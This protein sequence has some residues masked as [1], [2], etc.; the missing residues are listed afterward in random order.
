[1]LVN[2]KL[3][4]AE[5]PFKWR[6]A[7]EKGG[8]FFSSSALT[9]SN[10]GYEKICTQFNI[11]VLM[12]NLGAYNV[13]E[14]SFN[15]NS[16]KLAIKHFQMAASIF[17]SL[18]HTTASS[19]HTSELSFDL[20]SDVLNL[21]QHIMLA[22][23][24]ETF[25]FKASNDQMKVNSIA[26]IVAQCEDFYSEVNKLMQNI[27]YQSKLAIPDWVEV[28]QMKQIAYKGIAEY[29]QALVAQQSKDF[30]E[31]I[32]RLTKA[33][34]LLNSIESK[35]SIPLADKFKEI[36]NKAN[37]SL[38]E[39]KRDNDFIY[40][41][42][43]P[44]YKSLP[45]VSKA[46]L[47][48]CI[49]VAEIFYPGETDLLENL[50]PFGVHKSIQSLDQQ[51][52][53]IVN[54]EISKLREATQT[55]NAILASLNLP[56]AIEDVEGVKVPQSM[57]SKADTIKEKGGI[58]ELEKL[59]NELPDLLK[60]N[61]EIID[62]ME[63]S[64]NGEEESDNKLREQFGAKWTRAASNK[65]NKTWREH[66]VKYRS[67]LQ[68]ATD[69]DQ[70]VN[71]K[72]NANREKMRLLS[73]ATEVSLAQAIPSNKVDT[74][75]MD[76]SAVNKL[77]ELLGHVETLKREREELENQIKN[78]EFD[79]MKSKFIN[80][81]NLHQDVNESSLQSETLAEFYGDLQ[82]KVRQSLEKQETLIGHI[83]RANDAFVSQKGGSGND[84]DQF[85]KEL[86]TAHDAFVELFANL[87]E[88]TTFYNNLT[89]LLVNLQVKVND[90][91]FARKAERE[92]L[93]K[94][95]Q[96]EVVSRPNDPV[97]P[98]PA[99]QT[100]AAPPAANPSKPERPLP[101]SIQSTNPFSVPPPPQSH[102]PTY[103][104][105]QPQTIHYPH[106]QTG[107]QYNYYPPP[108]LP[109]GYNPYMVAPQP[110]K[111]WIILLYFL[112]LFFVS[113][114]SILSSTGLPL[115]RLS[116]IP[117]ASTSIGLCEKSEY[118]WFPLLECISLLL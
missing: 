14:S 62:D 59:I 25:Y 75:D 58:D 37:Q 60:R 6:D 39:V 61:K 47:A 84:R 5:I 95:L 34:E 108:P 66:I 81:F 17:Q 114:K 79:Q 83:R 18:K 50:L 57:L 22:Q 89:Q 104:F 43:I 8:Y 91:C 106:P 42:K 73:N 49:D 99:Y 64:L 105:Y 87:K 97:P 102:P 67:I 72:F 92:E 77:R 101:P 3:P 82:R 56:A 28:F 38:E 12:S 40:H 30:G 21:L 1:M 9:V 86:A 100:P 24:Q 48:K 68:N 44:D 4:H 7:F 13:K 93:C 74:S 69:A 65:L 31:Q 71:A 35:V 110:G 113:R 52:Q 94:D 117:T 19:A 36:V 45:Q 26:R 41:A 15:D 46:L 112:T 27:P 16:L 33:L 90:F 96:N 98:A 10:I 53:S 55:I 23:A 107:P 51:K 111:I 118:F 63:R 103:P 54:T 11:A 80:A 2:N 85:L 76:Q 29:Y 109:P 115:S 32:A 70:K 20:Q 78:V 116:R 88:G